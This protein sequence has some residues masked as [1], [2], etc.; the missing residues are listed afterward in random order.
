MRGRKR[1]EGWN[2]GTER[3]ADLPEAIRAGIV[4]MV[5]AAIPPEGTDRQAVRES[6]KS[7]KPDGR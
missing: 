3:W 2:R 6:R 1:V 7:R 4:A 5:R